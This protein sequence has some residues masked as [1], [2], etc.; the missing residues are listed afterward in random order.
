[1]E[2]GATHDV[3]K[4]ALQKENDELKQKLRELQDQNEHLMKNHAWNLVASDESDE[5][6]APNVS[7]ER[8]FTE[9]EIDNVEPLYSVLP[10]ISNNE[11]RQ[12]LQEDPTGAKNNM[13]TQKEDSKQ[14]GKDALKITEESH[15]IDP[16][17]C[18]NEA[19]PVDDNENE[20]NSLME[21]GSLELAQPTIAPT[22]LQR[23]DGRTAP[24]STPGA[25]AI[26]PT[27]TLNA[28]SRQEQEY[29]D[30]ESPSLNTTNNDQNGEEILINAE[31]IE[32]KEYAT[33]SPLES[34]HKTLLR[35][36]RVRIGIAVVIVFMIALAVGISVALST[37]VTEPPE[38]EITKLCIINGTNTNCTK[39]E[40]GSENGSE[41]ED[42]GEGS[43]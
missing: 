13:Q 42:E 29:N 35:Q 38:V 25:F 34:A 2:E 8:P 17:K 36:R 19:L 30:E 1:M 15:V 37:R 10:V 11:T 24:V 20:K 16:N 33:A 28:Q 31:L 5:E 32:E 39:T 6:S 9:K 41:D 3:E 18:A 22:S 27:T 26:E 4:D 40:N 21:S 7:I 43:E 14:D 23:Q 12:D